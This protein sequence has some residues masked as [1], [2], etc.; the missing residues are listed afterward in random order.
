MIKEKIKI[1]LLVTRV[2]QGENFNQQ[3]KGG[4]YAH[5]RAQARAYPSKS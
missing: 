1:P 3:G 4:H 2:L 5:S